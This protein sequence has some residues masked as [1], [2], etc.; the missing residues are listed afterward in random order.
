MFGF[1]HNI[2]TAEVVIIAALIILFFGGK[3]LSEFAQGMR[4]SKKEFKKIKEELEK[5]EETK[6][7]PS[8]GGS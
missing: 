5:P 8:G 4:E 3:K 6:S 1:L 2:G 7:N